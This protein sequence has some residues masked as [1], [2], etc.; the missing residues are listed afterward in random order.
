M[1]KI[2]LFITIITITNCFAQTDKLWKSHKGG[3]VTTSKNVARPSFPKDFQLYQLNIAS[4]KQILSNAKDRFS[5]TTGVIISLPNTNGKLEQFEVFEAS[6]FAPELQAQFPNIRAYVGRSLDDEYAQ[7]RMSISPQGIQT[8]VFR[9]EARTEFMEPYSADGSVYA[10]Y[11]SSRNKGSLPFT[12]ITEDKV[13]AESLNKQVSHQRSS[14]S[15]LLTFRLALSCTGE[16]G[17]SFGGAVGALAQ[18]NATMTRVNGVFEKDFSIHMNIIA[19]NN[20]VVYTDATTDP[21]SAAANKANWNAE[22]QSTLTS[23]IGEANYDV[24]HLFGASGGGGN[25]GCIGCVCVDGTKGRG[26]TSPGSGLAMGDTFD[27]DYVAHE[28]GHQFGGNHTFS[29]GVEGYGVNVEPGSGSTIMGYAGITGQDVQANSDDY[30]HYA[31]INQVEVNMV[32]KSCPVRTPIANIAPVVNAGINYTIPK[33]TPFVL[34]GTGSDVN[35]DALTYCWEQT[36]TATTETLAASTASDTKV[37]G[38][39]WRSYDPVASPSRYFP[40]LTSVIANTAFTTA[41]SN[42]ATPIKTEYLSSVARTLNFSF[43]GRDN[44]IGGGLTRSDA[45]V[46]TVNGT[47]GP[48]LVNIP[49]TNVSWAPGSNQTVT[50]AVAGTTA[51]GVNAA[52][53]DIYLSNDGG[54]TYPVLLAGK[55]PNDGSETVS[56]PN[57]AGT[58]NRIMI[59]GNN[60]VFYD[61]SNT[62]FTIAAPTSTFALASSGVTDG[63]YKGVCQGTTA[64]Y[65]LNYTTI[66]GFSGN[67]TFGITG[68]PVGSTVTFSPTSIN[69]NGIVTVTISDTQLCAP[70]FYTMIVTGTSGAV[71]KTVNLYLEVL[72]ASFTVMSLT[73]PTNLAVAQPTNPTLNWAADAAA[74]SYDVQVATDDAFS[75]I[76]V[77]GNVATNS[78]VLS[79]LTPATNYFWKVLP[80]NAGCSGVYSSSYRF[81]TG[82][83]GVPACNNFASTNIPLTISASGTPTVDSIITIPS[84]S[85][86]TISDLNITAQI[87]HSYTSDL[88]ITL[89]SPIGTQVQLVTGKCTSNNNINATFDDAGATLVCGTNPAIVGTIK[90]AQLLSAF[91]GQLSQGI[92]TLRVFDN[93]T[94]DGGSI[95]NWSLNICNNTFSSTTCGQIATIWNGTS[96]SNGKPLDNVAATINGNYVSSGNLEVCSLNVTGTAQVTFSSGHNLTVDGVVNVAGTASLTMENNANL[97]QTQNVSNLGIINVKRNT[98]TL[99]R[100]DYALW[101]SPVAPQLLQSFSPATLAGRFYTYN[102]STNLYVAVSTP[103]ATNFA[104]GSGYLIRMPNN[105]PVTPTIWNGIFT[106]TPNNGNVNVTVTNATFNALGNPYPSTIDADAFISANSITEALYFWRKTNNTLTTSYATYTLAGGVGTANSGDPLG[107]VPNGI[108]QVGQGFIAK[109]TATNVA[110]T[111]SMRVI[112]NNNQFLRTASADKSRFWLNLTNI[113]GIFCQ[114]MVAYMPNATQGIDAAIDGRFFNDSQTA[115]TSVINSE[116]FAIQGRALPFDTSDMVP[117]GFKSELAGNYTI[118]LDHVDG[119]FSTGQAVYL[120]DNLTNTSHNLGTGSYAFASAAGIFNSRFEIIYQNPLNVNLPVF[121]ENSVIVYKNNGAI[122]INSGSVIIDNVKI[123]DISG[124]LLIEKNKVNATETAINTSKFGTQ[125]LIVQITS[126]AQIKVSKKVVN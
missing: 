31:T 21:Y 1:K 105:H 91:N 126:S 103:T 68:N 59:K 46:V 78:Y 10:V 79:G 66:A 94:G 4:M 62:N 70:G 42:D 50:W 114:T 2:L 48:F 88:T 55:V 24:G 72:N 69:T 100:L 3:A 22:L 123:F 101:S 8:M 83:L 96:W 89:I 34:T 25:A 77:N 73:S 99:M 17:T 118:A 39:N 75:N 30:F 60:H 15:E 85:N 113:S 111:N 5:A 29:H 112:D 97:I 124:R 76:I 98:P 28:L 33:S 117:L 13:M 56:I 109:S 119:L 35:G 95:T 116:E 102:P 26:F 86:V 27:I 82:A 80:K 120:K 107:I 115:L 37:G 18:M 122:H 81:T 12:C 40:N 61:I 125:V 19:N 38:P 106:G 110:F 44:V 49:N 51:N 16:Y 9:T 32:G 90:P 57:S 52:Y 64:I 54:N 121:D 7:L 23:V 71:D 92:W 20:L 104:T 65:D 58:A 47:A 14:T 67:T 41:V 74:T 93:A 36:D 11:N 84:G 108:I 63:Q 43:T 87:T 45:M 6:N 53:V